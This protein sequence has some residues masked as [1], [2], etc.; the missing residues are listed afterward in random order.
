MICFPSPTGREEPAPEVLL[1]GGGAQR[2]M[3]VRIREASEMSLTPGCA[4]RHG[5]TSI[6]F[7]DP[8]PSPSP[9]GRGAKIAVA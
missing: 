2:R 6:N 7:P 4:A 5:Q 3:R 1:I 9:D 8:H